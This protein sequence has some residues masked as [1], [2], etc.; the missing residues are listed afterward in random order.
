MLPSQ[1]QPIPLSSLPKPR[2]LRAIWVLLLTDLL[3][4]GAALLLAVWIRYL[5]DRSL[6]WGLYLEAWP[7]VLLFPIAYALAGLYPGFGIAPPEEFRRLTYSI[8]TVFILI[9]ASTFM[10]KTGADYSRGAFVFAWL[11]LLLLAPVFR[12]LAREL[13][14]RQQWWPLPV[15]VLGAGKTGEEVVAS[16][17]RRPSLG[18]RPVMIFDDSLE[19]QNTS[20]L[21]IPVMGRLDT[22][23]ELALHSGVKHAIIAMPG[24]EREQLMRMLETHSRFFP[25][26]ILIPNLFGFS[27]L[28][29]MPRDLGGILGL[30]IKQ[31]LLIAGSKNL[32]RMLDLTLIT[33]FALPTLLLVGIIA[34][35]I[36]LDSPGPVFYSHRRIGHG[37]RFFDAW[38]FRSM[39]PD[40]EKVLKE[41]LATHPELLEE[42]DKDQKLRDDPR[43]TS[44]GR[45]LRKTSLDE[46]PQLWNILKGEMSLVGP[47]PIV[48]AEIARYGDQFGLYT[49][50]LPGLAG[51][52]QVS[53]RNDITYHERVQLDAFY[54]RNWSVWL[55]I[56]IL[57]RT[58]WVVL[59]SKGAY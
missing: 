20:I 23:I 10:Y 57:A 48:E 18:L 37:G 28:W 36:R 26:I 38:K 32:K 50:V 19:K 46:I 1:P 31:R 42:W 6:I 2:R 15:F 45:I 21:S 39:V 3:A 9:G 40:A 52:W 4:V 8:S 54:V 43:I 14:C 22:A 51:L 59:F 35:L 56:Y 29:V 41:Y 34:L 13:F 44:I 17:L 11:L 55:D 33:L 30:E 49:Q 24:V 58:I 5:Y 47:R 7:I 53:G 12:A 16:L 27:S 25:H